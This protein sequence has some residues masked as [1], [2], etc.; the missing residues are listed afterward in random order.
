MQKDIPLQLVS[1]LLL[2]ATSDAFYDRKDYR[3]FFKELLQCSRCG[4]KATKNG[5]IWLKL[6]ADEPLQ[7]PALLFMPLK[8]G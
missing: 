1:R 4:F 6:E 5:R 7:V 2:R 8:M 3:T